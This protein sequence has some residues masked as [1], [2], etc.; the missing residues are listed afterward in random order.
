[1]RVA[2]EVG[3]G[4]TLRSDNAQ[5]TG[6]AA[7]MLHIR[8]SVFVYSRYIKCIALRDETGFSV[9]EFVV[10]PGILGEALK[11]F[12][13]AILLLRGLD[14]IGKHD[15]CELMRHCLVLKKVGRISA[16]AIM[17]TLFGR[18]RGTCNLA[19]EKVAHEISNFLP[20]RFQSEVPGIQQVILEIFEIPLVWFRA[21][22]GE[23]L[24]IL[25][26]DN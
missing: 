16:A 6:G 8:P 7:A 11:A 12:P 19:V 24:V 13:G 26:P 22:R 25:A 20:M 23:D 9:G 17:A 21:G 5:K 1:M 3:L 4:E 2:P 18:Q 15:F 10:W 14:A